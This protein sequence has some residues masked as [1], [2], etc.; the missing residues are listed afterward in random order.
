[1]KYIL[2]TAGAG[3]HSYINKSNQRKIH[4]KNLF[5]LSFVEVTSPPHKGVIRGVFLAT[6][7][8]QLT[9]IKI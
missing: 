2:C 1:M 6:K 4:T 8:K 3:G 5:H 7:P 9:R